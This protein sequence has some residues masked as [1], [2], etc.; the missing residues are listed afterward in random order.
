MSLTFNAPLDTN[1]KPGQPK[2]SK[3]E[4][5]DPVSDA[6]KR[7]RE[8]LQRQQEQISKRLERLSDS[9]RKAATI[10]L[11]A[12]DPNDDPQ[13]LFKQVR[14]LLTAMRLANISDAGKTE[15]VVGQSDAKG[16]SLYK[17]L[18]R[19]TAEINTDIIDHIKREEKS[20]EYIKWTSNGIEVCVWEKYT[21]PAAGL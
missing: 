1:N 4:K 7:Q 17:V 3:P 12:D 10:I 9:V 13:Y 19:R 2:P 8:Q 20:L 14:P 11:S 16:N 15:L 5:K 6:K 18:L 21:P